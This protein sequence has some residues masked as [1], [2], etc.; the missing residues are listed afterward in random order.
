MQDPPAAPK[1]LFKALVTL[2]DIHIIN[3]LKIVQSP[4]WVAYRKSKLAKLTP[5]GEDEEDLPY[6]KFARGFHWTVTVYRTRHTLRLFVRTIADLMGIDIKNIDH[7]LVRDGLPGEEGVPQASEAL[8]ELLWAAA[9]D[10]LAST[11]PAKER[12]DTDWLTKQ[13]GLD[14]KTNKPATTWG[15][16]L[17]V[18]LGLQKPGESILSP[19]VL[20]NL[21]KGQDILWPLFM[22][23]LLDLPRFLPSTDSHFR[24]K[25]LHFSNYL[26]EMWHE[27]VAVNHLSK[28]LSTLDTKKGT[29]R[30]VTAYGPK[31]TPALVGK[32]RS[33]TSKCSTSVFSFTSH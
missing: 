14:G 1:N 20:A 32:Y 17:L 26:Q 27:K 13:C 12:A 11:R 19:D 30:T 10:D 6:D 5:F 21:I 3:I 33:R 4:D 18:H 28:Q 23:E 24:L 2:P 8:L 29:V 25:V 22:P 16:I 7:E 15:P 31:A 9:E